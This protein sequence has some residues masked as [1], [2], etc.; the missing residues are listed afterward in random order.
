MKKIYITIVLSVF[1]L[2]TSCNDLELEPVN[3]VTPDTFYI[4]AQNLEAGLNGIYS[5]LQAR[6]FADYPSLEG[7]S[8]NAISDPG[9]SAPDVEAFAAG[10]SVVA[11]QGFVRMYSNN[12]ELIQRANLLLNN[13]D[14][15]AAIPDETRETIRAE[16]RALRAFSYMNLVYL[17]GD[18]PLFETFLNRNDA[19]SVSR[20]PR[21]TVVQF[22]LDEFQMAANNLGATPAGEGRLTK[23]AVLGLH[24]RAMLYEARLGNQ[25]WS[26][27][28][29]VI[30]N[31]ITNADNGGNVLV[32]TDNPSSDYQS[33]FTEANENNAEFIF[34]IRNNFNDL[35]EDYEENYS[36]FAGRLK[37]H[38]HQNLADAY[39][40]ADGTAYNPSDDTYVERDPRLSANIMH[41]GLTFNGLTYDGTDA[42]G[43]VGGNSLNSITNLFFH[44]FVTTDY[45]A[46]FNEGQLDLP[47]LRYAELL[48]MQAEARNETGTGDAFEPINKVRD[49][50]GLPGLTGLSQTELRDAIILERR[51]ELAME[52]FRWFD[53]ITLGIAETTINSIVEESDEITRNFTANRN[54]LLPIPQTE[55][56]LNGNLSQ[57]PGY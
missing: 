6:G 40:Y 11:T 25:T 52:G 36:W 1:L 21:A 13:I 55:I 10:Q 19:L 5:Q 34:S 30:N 48:L 33:L 35:G 53:L 16:A 17:F 7:M 49:R 44:K 51:L 54:E 9:G 22:V 27:V 32:D 12:Y 20:T 15:I 28:L 41:E 43:F 31:T 42:G 50:A 56:D 45:T 8:D 39:P 37:F 47:V 14:G 4:N 24:A 57:N 29:T 23:Q 26:D 18:V 2:N 46:T 38:V 3:S